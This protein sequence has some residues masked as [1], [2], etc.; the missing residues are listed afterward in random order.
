MAVRLQAS[1]FFIALF[2]SSCFETVDQIRS[3]SMSSMIV[4]PRK[5]QSAG[6]GQSKSSPEH[7]VAFSGPCSQMSIPNRQQLL[8]RFL[9]DE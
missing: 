3:V 2:A 1:R 5:F 8:L 6:W 4:F 7:A 9:L